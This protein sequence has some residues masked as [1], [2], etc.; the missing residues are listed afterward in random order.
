MIATFEEIAG[1]LFVSRRGG[2]IKPYRHVIADSRQ[3]LPQD[4]FVAIRGANV[5]G[6]RFIGDAIAAGATVIIHQEELPEYQPGIT[7]I[8]VADS[9]RVYARILR[10]QCHRPDETVRLFGVT[11]TNGK[12]TTAYLIEHLLNH[13][14]VPCGLV[15][16]VEYRDGKRTLPADR[17]TP[18]PDVLFPLLDEMR[19]NGMRAAALELSSHALAQGRIDG[20]RFRCAIFTNLTGDHLDYHHDMESYFQAKLQLFKQ[21]LAPDGSVVVNI[22]DPYGMR[23]TR[24]ISGG[25]QLLT[26]GENPAAQW[27]LSRIE[28]D[29]E[30][31]RFRLEGENGAFDVGCNL[32]GLHNVRNLAGALLAV[33]D[34]GVSPEAIDNALRDP[35]LVP[36]RLE[37][38][39]SP[40]G[41]DFFVD[42]AHSDDALRNV[43]SILRRTA[44]GRVIVVFGA[45]G[46]R[47][48]SKRPRMGAAAAAGADLLIVTSDNPRSEV[49]EAIID[50]ICAGIPAG[51][52]F[53]RVPDRAAAIAR[54]AELA[55]PGDTVLVAGKGHENYQEI[56]GERFHFSDREVIENLFGDGAL[57]N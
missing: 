51:T 47:D 34:F 13:A 41:V 23:L 15:S 36:G 40:A 8:R 22:D 4:T 2:E 9:A 54:A 12:T 17:T 25:R 31:S 46:D 48:R 57:R 11:G 43:L 53:E 38:L 6:H 42:Y 45:G 3:V 55:Q 1:E 24:E 21:I 49:P 14:G 56:G 7:Y 32:I 16:T 19:L 5:D 52:R 29:S 50:D 20:A 44:R 18:G 35:I 30:G 26:F 10:E 27:R 37:K 39:T 33:L 28:L